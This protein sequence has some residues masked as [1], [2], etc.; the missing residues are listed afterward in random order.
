MND[1]KS[2][3]EVRQMIETFNK[4]NERKIAYEIFNYANSLADVTYY[5][6]DGI[7]FKRDN[8]KYK[9]LSIS[10]KGSRVL[11]HVPVTERDSVFEEFRN[12]APIYL[13]V[14][15]RDKNQIDILLRDINSFNDIKPLID[16]AYSHRE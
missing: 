12:F 10:T 5:I 7:M 4:P 9:F 1:V 11:F 15:K 8:R 6:T 13:A 2:W 3:E 14:D 16:Y